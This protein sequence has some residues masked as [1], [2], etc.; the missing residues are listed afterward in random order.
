LSLRPRAQPHG[1]A[2]PLPQPAHASIGTPYPYDWFAHCGMV[3]IAFAG[4]VWKVDHPVTV[5]AMHPDA[6][7]VTWGPPVVPGYVTPVSAN[8]LRF[9]APTYITGV[10]LHRTTDT[11][12]LCS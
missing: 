1:Y 12:P 4:K 6:N 7:G 9:D 10:T 11:I 5:P 8:E 3:Y 2:G